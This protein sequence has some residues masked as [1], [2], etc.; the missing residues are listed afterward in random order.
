MEIG[1]TITPLS[2]E[3]YYLLMHYPPW[4]S[5]EDLVSEKIKDLVYVSSRVF[6]RDSTK[7]S[8]RLIWK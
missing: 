1:K 7:F 5:V 3:V 6:V 4:Y 8:M 2:Y